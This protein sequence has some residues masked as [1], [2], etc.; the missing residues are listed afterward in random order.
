[1]GNRT[2]FLAL[3]ILMVVAIVIG[4]IFFYEHF[5]LLSLFILLFACLPFVLHF[6]QQKVSS[7]ELVML[8]MLGAIA[9]VSRVP[10]API[11]SVQPTSFFIIVTGIV[12]GPQSGFVVGMLA[13]IISNMF[14]GQGPWT[15]WQMF[16]W[17]MMGLVAGL[18]RNTPFMTTKLGRCVY[19]FI[20]G[21][22]FG[23]L[24]NAYVIILMIE[25]FSWKAII[26]Y[27]VAS[28]YFD[29]A[30]AV[31][32]VIFLLL[33]SHI[34]IKLIERFKLKYGLFQKSL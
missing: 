34:F 9:A 4:T 3:F 32:N 17:G 15:P 20:V 16:A 19:G 7:R 1:M 13:A 30:H 5:M 10:F 24:M 23:W 27:Y 25:Q 11:P 6:N 26:P 18:L 12:L 22:L 21:F 29:L 8:A 28:F 14:L 2:K 33:F 31:S